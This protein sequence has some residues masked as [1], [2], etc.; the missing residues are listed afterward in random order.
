MLETCCEY[1]KKGDLESLKNL[2]L[3]E[4]RIDKK[5]ACIEVEDSLAI[6]LSGSKSSP[7][8]LAAQTG[9]TNVVEFLLAKFPFQSFIDFPCTVFQIANTGDEL[10]NCTALNAASICGHHQ[11]VE[12]LLEAG[13]SHSIRDCTGSTPFL[14]AAYHG[15]Y[16]VLQVL[17]RYGAD[18][19]A[20]NSSRWTAFLIAIKKCNVK[21]LHFLLQIGVDVSHKTPEGFGPMFV[22]IETSSVIAKLLLKHGL[23]LEFPEGDSSVQDRTPC[24][25]YL[26]ALT[27]K[28]L[29]ELLSVRSD[30]PMQYR[31]NS[32]L[33]QGVQMLFCACQSRSMNN[34]AHLPS[35]ELW[36]SVFH[37]LE[38]NKIKISILPPCDAYGGRSELVTTKELVQKCDPTKP[39]SY[40]E[41][42][43]QAVIILERCMGGNLHIV[44]EYMITFA[45][46]LHSLGLVCEAARIFLRVLYLVEVHHLPLLQKGYCPPQ[47]YEMFYSELVKKMLRILWSNN[48][49]LSVMYVEGFLPFVF[50]VLKSLTD[51]SEL[52]HTAYGCLRWSPR[53][54]LQLTIKT[55]S[56]WIQLVLHC[57][58]HSREE[59]W[60]MYG[61]TF[62]SSFLLQPDGCNLLHIVLDSPNICNAKVLEFLLCWGAEDIINM[63]F[64]GKRCLQKASTSS[65]RSIFD[66]LVNHSAHLD[67]VDRA[68]KTV[69]HGNPNLI[70]KYGLLPLT[71][72][73]AKVIVKE[74][75]PYETLLYVPSRVKNFI[76]MHDPDMQ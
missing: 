59:K 28:P 67:A 61:R 35:Y 23:S 11:I 50:N 8:V 63:P 1:A 51:Q 72:Q 75:I 52:E 33:L 60:E 69:L 70:Q 41:M 64:E 29:F 17:H 13:A 74:R 4:Y 56:D 73:A 76:R 15:R 25:L 42:L 20:V 54:L 36:M 22:A 40:V 53:I 7:L 66:V 6:I 30:C 31:L 57:Q 44:Y 47:N 3:D 71:C 43:Y 27:S 65:M 16:K 14:E 34:V 55:F 48:A 19:N 32:L 62:V 58:D 21:I 46:A 12:L 26:A 45:E 2:L 38:A 10:H 5:D 39:N 37:L 68:G 9:H 18:I 24:P 49:V